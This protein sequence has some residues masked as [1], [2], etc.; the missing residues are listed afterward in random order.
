MKEQAARWSWSRAPGFVKWLAASILMTANVVAADGFLTLLARTFSLTRWQDFQAY[1]VAA[2]LLNASRPLYSSSEV[3]ALARALGL[4]PPAYIYP[5][6]FAVLLRPL[7]LFPFS[8]AGAL[9]M[10]LNLTALGVTLL[11]LARTLRL[12]FWKINS[13]IFLALLLPSTLGSVQQG[14]PPLLLTLLIAAALAIGAR[15]DPTR[16]NVIAGSLLAVAGAFK[17]Y[18]AL[19]ALIYFPHRRWNSLPPLWAAELTISASTGNRS[20]RALRV[21]IY[22][23]PINRRSHRFSGGIRL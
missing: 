15:S 11:L 13:L 16:E 7:A 5:P 6:F 8:T 1:Y 22:V 17:I 10:G 20:S 23:R 19:I 2:R 4:S 9:W 14:Q 3:A 18:P 21:S 12:S